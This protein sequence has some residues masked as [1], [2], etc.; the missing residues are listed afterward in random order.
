MSPDL[1]SQAVKAYFQA[2]RDMDVEAW[3][4]TFAE[5]AV[6]NDPVGSP[7]MV[8]HDKLREFLQSVAGAFEKVGLTE[9]Q[10]FIAGNGA[11][12]KWTG[13]GTSKQGK[14]VHFESIDVIEVNEEGKIR[15]V[16]AYWNPAEM[17]AQL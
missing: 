5:D 14:P 4:N 13:R 11:A 15:R 16:Y 9:D 8:G 6:S 3:V 2:L 12:V 7:P 10:V 1:I 17:V